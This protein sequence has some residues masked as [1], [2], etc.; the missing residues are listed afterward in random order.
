MTAPPILIPC[1]R[2]PRVAS[3]RRIIAAV[4]LALTLPNASAASQQSGTLVGTVRDSA[5]EPVLGALIAAT[6]TA[7]ETRSRR[8]GTFSLSLSAGSWRLTV[9]RLGYQPAALTVS[10]PRSAPSDTLR[11]VLDR[12]PIMLHGLTVQAPGAPPMASTI[13]PSTIRAAPAVVEPDVFRALVLVPGVSQPNDLKSSIHLAGGASDETGV[14]LDGFPLQN[15]FHLTGVLGAVNV[16]ML[17]RADLRMTDL[18]ADMDGRLSGVIDLTTRVT[19]AHATGDASASVI[20]TGVTVSAPALGTESDV[21]ASGRVSYLDRAIEAIAAG[22]GRGRRGLILPGYHDAVLRLRREPDTGWR[23]EALAFETSDYV[24][25]PDVPALADNPIRWGETLL[26]GRVG[27]GTPSWRATAA[28]SQSRA[29]VFLNTSSPL[30]ED[31]P[32][33]DVTRVWDDATLTLEQHGRQQRSRIG[34]FWQRREYDQHWR[35]LAGAHEV[36]TPNVPSRFDGTSAQERVGLFADIAREAARDLRG[37]IG[38]RATRVGDVT[39]LGP[40]AMVT[41][42]GIPGITAA[43]AY[44]RRFQFDAQVEEPIEFSFTQPEFLLETPRRLDVTGIDIRWRPKAVRRAAVR[45]LSVQAF[46]KR[47]RDQTSLPDTGSVIA[48]SLSGAGTTRFARRAGR[49]YGAALGLDAQAGR[50]FLQGAYTYQ[51][52]LVAFPDGWWPTGWDAPHALT[53]LAGI[54]LGRSWTLSTALQWRSGAAVPSP[55]AEILVPN[56]AA[57]GNVSTRLLIGDRNNTRL[58]DYHRVD[59]GIRRSWQGPRIGGAMSLQVINLLAER[60]TLAYGW[61]DFSCA[62]NGRCRAGSDTERVTF[63]ILPTFGVEIHW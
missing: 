51:R 61:S 53:G 40:R 26:G 19:A 58:P 23:A 24:R 28:T 6:G 5:G 45:S 44:N 52:S 17:D 43:V 13:T 57:P 29:R 32:P 50:I 37:T 49:G 34:A 36:L 54:S 15:P 27:Y 11:V 31:G 48:D 7:W 35:L 63:P 47:Y 33:V 4:S 62:P 3:A 12:A 56:P 60:N 22:T 2:P 25:F 10:M 16:A 21:L 20:T 39:A 42:T 46:Y 18:P 30:T 8:D 1:G 9:Q 41:W 38:L 14:L 59:L 55:V